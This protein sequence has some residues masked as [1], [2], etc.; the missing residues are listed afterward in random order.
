[1][2]KTIITIVAAVG[3]LLT[4]CG[5]DLSGERDACEAG[6]MEA[7]DDLYWESPVGSDDERFGDTCGGRQPA[8]MGMWCGSGVGR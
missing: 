7:C 6:D 8:G 2:R 4:G 1:M 5:A 3:L